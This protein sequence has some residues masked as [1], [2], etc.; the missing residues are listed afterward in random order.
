MK[1]SFIFGSVMEALGISL[2]AFTGSTTELG[3]FFRSI[4]LLLKWISSG[5]HHAVY[6]PLPLPPLSTNTTCMGEGVQKIINMFFGFTHI[7][8]CL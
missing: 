8:H 4:P 6:T 3:R 1:V 5:Y 7:F 2:P